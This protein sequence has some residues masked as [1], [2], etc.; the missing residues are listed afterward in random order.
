M[1]AEYEKVDDF[2]WQSALVEIEEEFERVCTELCPD[3]NMLCN[4]ILDLCYTKSSTK[5]FA[6]R[7]CGSTII[8]NLLEFNNG[9]VK[10]P[11]PDDSGDISYAGKRFSLHKKELSI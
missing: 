1:F 9:V 7:M 10:Y 2:E 6:W 4:V 3:E 5:R 11:I 8:R